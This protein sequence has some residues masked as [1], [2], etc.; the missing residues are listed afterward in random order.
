MSSPLPPVTLIL[1]EA[2]GAVRLAVTAPV[3]ADA[4]NVPVAVEEGA[5]KVAVNETALS[6]VTTTL[7]KDV[8]TMVTP[9]ES[10]AL[11]VAAPVETTF[12]VSIPGYVKVTPAVVAAP[13]KVSVAASAVPTTAAAAL[14]TVTSLL[15]EFKVALTM[16]CAFVKAT[17]LLTTLLL[18]T[19][20]TLL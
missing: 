10:V 2:V 14:P 20:L 5:T 11:P 4:S 15:T 6:P 12:S 19:Q 7:L 16:P 13:V 8:S 18:F 1:P 17:A 9:V 3:A